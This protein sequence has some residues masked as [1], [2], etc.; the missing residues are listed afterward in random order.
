MKKNILIIL[1]LATLFLVNCSDVL[2]RPRLVVATDETFWESETKLRLYVNGFYTNY[3]VGYNSGWSVDYAPLRGYELSDNFT[4]N[5]RLWS[6]ATQSP[7]TT[8]GTGESVGWLQSYGGAG[9][10]FGWVR[11]VNILIDKLDNVMKGKYLSNDE[12]AHWMAAARFFRGFEYWKLVH[13]F[14]NIQYYDAPVPDTD[15]DLLYKDRDDRTFVMDKVYDDLVF[16]LENMRYSDGA[17]NLNRYIAAGF[18]SRF[19][20]FEGTWQK[21]HLNNT[22]KAK[23]Y[24]ELAVKAAS[25][26]MQS[27]NYAFTS[28]FRSLFG[29]FNLSGNKEVLMYRHYEAGFVTHH[30]A[31][32]S[33]TTETQPYAPNLDLAKS[34][35]CSDGNPWKLSSMADA[36][37]FDIASF[38]KTRDSRFEATF[39]SKAERAS[40]SL[41]YAQKFIDRKGPTQ[42]P[43]PYSPEYGSNT[44]TNDAPIIRLAEVVLNWIEAKAEL[45]TMGGAA[46]TQA[47]IDASVNAIR[48]RPLD[49]VAIGKGIQ[50]TQPLL[51]SSLPNDP[52]RDTDVPPLLWEIRRERRMEFVFEFS[53][54][55]DIRRWKKLHYLDFSKPEYADKRYGPWVNMPV[56][57][58][59]WMV[60]GRNGINRVVKEDGTIVVYQYGVN[61]QNMVGYFFPP[62]FDNRLVTPA[63]KHYLAPI[64]INTIAQYKERGYTLTQTPG[65][66]STN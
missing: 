20:L 17:M 64:G 63:D 46:V 13:S 65:W 3:F 36:N 22:E 66:N 60:T 35:I 11:K 56:E 37:K 52:D 45:A 50:K 62:N 42:Y 47:D 12:Y 29:S 5:G 9:Y 21:Y 23:K 26:V 14:G 16:A 25:I 19:M 10:N 41:L 8:G 58:P 15:M 4:Q 53:R 18:I 38:V 24:L 31:S 61:E 39:S 1:S 59:E 44:N 57:V 30:I 32:Y 51:L 55:M 28:D 2:D 33:N 6:Y 34:F 54:L 49:A 7:T 48:N 43:G 40:S 27:G